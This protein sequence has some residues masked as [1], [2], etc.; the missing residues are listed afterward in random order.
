MISPTHWTPWMTR[1]ALQLATL[2][3]VTTSILTLSPR[4]SD[5]QTPCENP[6]MCL[7]PA[8]I[9]ATIDA[10][11]TRAREVE[12]QHGPLRKRLAEKETQVAVC[13]GELRAAHQE[14]DRLRAEQNE[15][16]PWW[17]RVGL[18]VTTATLGGAAGVGLVAD[19]PEGV[20][21]SLVTAA[22][23]SLVGRLIVEVV[24]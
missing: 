9:N 7:S 3:V 12:A 13:G 2:L 16:V 11:C 19:V 8:E 10:A 18:D 24:D 20:R 6:A 14:I 4:R 22:A 23:A 5:A 21:W 1:A 15:R 17:L